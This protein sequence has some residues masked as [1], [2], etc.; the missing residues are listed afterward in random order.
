MIFNKS[1]AERGNYKGVSFNFIKTNLEK[2]EKF[3]NPDESNTIIDKKHANYSKINQGMV[4][5][6][7]MIYKDDV[8]I[9]KI[10]ELPKPTDH[11][12]YRDN[13]VTYPYDEPAIVEGVTRAFDQDDEEFCKVKLGS[14]RT[15]GIGDKFCCSPDHEVLTSDG[16]ISIDAITMEHLVATLNNDGE[17]EY[18][19]PDNIYEF[20]H[21]DDIYKID[22]TQINLVT[23]LNHKMYTSLQKPKDK[24]DVSTYTLQEVNKLIGQKRY[25]KKNAINLQWDLDEWNIYAERDNDNDWYF[26]TEKTMNAWIWLLGIYLSE[27]WVDNSGSIRIATHKQRVKDKLNEILP[28]LGLRYICYDTQPDHWYIRAIEGNCVSIARWFKSNCYRKINDEIA[29]IAGYKCLPSE[30]WYLGQSQCELLIDALCLGDGYKDKRRENSMEYYTSSKYMADDFQR[31]CLH[32]GYACNV[33]LKRKAGEQLQINGNNTQ[34]NFNS[35]RLNII[36][37]INNLCPVFKHNEIFKEHYTGKVHCIEV[38]NHIFYIRNKGD[39]QK[40]VWTG[41]SSRAG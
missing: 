17:L 7:T 40:C 36:K 2:D 5:K 29:Y 38:P 30:C 37:G 10:I 27:G 33:M 8:V 1:A 41:N 18:R 39:K 28:K 26:N 13:S 19:R 12:T 6:G 3:A 15:L 34:R 35:Y 32:A 31:L 9:G 16:W 14:V 11:R 21:D 4:K 24:D 20:D 25:Y 22:N 23:T